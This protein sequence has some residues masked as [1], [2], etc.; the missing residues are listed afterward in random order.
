MKLIA[1]S[2]ADYQSPKETRNVLLSFC[3]CL[4]GLHEECFGVKIEGR[5][6]KEAL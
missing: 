3:F 6:D 4:R 2:T 1:A 5:V